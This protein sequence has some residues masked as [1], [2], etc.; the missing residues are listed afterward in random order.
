MWS[1]NQLLKLCKWKLGKWIICYL[2][3][4]K[5]PRESTETCLHV[6]TNMV[7]HVFACFCI[8]KR[9]EKTRRGTHYFSKKTQWVLKGNKSHK[10]IAVVVS[11][12]IVH[13][14]VVKTCQPFYQWP[15]WKDRMCCEIPFLSGDRFLGFAN[16]VLR[17]IV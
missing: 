16:E 13:L 12:W 14:D 17:T 8:L 4:M 3:F 9:T 15:L 11:S 7:F 6:F 5:K 2:N 10:N 1:R